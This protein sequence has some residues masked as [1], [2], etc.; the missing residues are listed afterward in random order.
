MAQDNMNYDLKSGISTLRVSRR[1]PLW[2]ETNTPGT[3]K[4]IA[5]KNLIRQ[6]VM[7]KYV[8][9]GARSS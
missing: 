9:V 8:S 1:D 4:H 5:G 6:T 2:M 3:I 7:G